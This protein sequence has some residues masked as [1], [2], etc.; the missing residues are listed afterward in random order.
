MRIILTAVALSALAACSGQEAAAPV[1]EQQAVTGEAGELG[2]ILLSGTAIARGG[3]QLAFG[4]PRDQADGLVAQA[5]AEGP[6][7]SANAE[8][9]AGPMEFS[10]HPGGLTLNYQDGKLVG[11]LLDEASEAV[12]IE[13]G[14]AIGA[15]RA[16]AEALPG[17]AAVDGSTLGD[18]FYS[19]SKGIGGFL[20]EGKVTMLYAGT[21]CF[22]R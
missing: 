5:G 10:R 11:W 12:T 15:G 3:E 20:E 22:F 21:N 17:V 19:E 14:L 9:G 2:P 13:G 16:V 1:A 4:S 6:E 8:C 7:S 18:E